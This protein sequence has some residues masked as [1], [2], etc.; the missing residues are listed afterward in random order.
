MVDT[1][2]KT[3]EERVITESQAKFVTTEVYNML[4]DFLDFL[5]SG[6]QLGG[7]TVD[8]EDEEHRKSL[9]REYIGYMIERTNNEE[10]E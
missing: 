6:E 9:V 4:T 8:L 10:T 5:I 2:N 7:H 1:T 3:M